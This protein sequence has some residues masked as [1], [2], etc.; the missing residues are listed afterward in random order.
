MGASKK[1]LFYTKKHNVSS[2]LNKAKNSFILSISPLSLKHPRL[3]QVTAHLY[4]W[5]PKGAKYSKLSIGK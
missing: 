3:V 1:I 2:V 4:D 5:A